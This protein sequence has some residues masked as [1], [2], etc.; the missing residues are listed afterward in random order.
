MCL[1]RSVIAG[2]C[3]IARLRERESAEYAQYTCYH[4]TEAYNA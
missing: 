3:C 2:L 4:Y 1:Q